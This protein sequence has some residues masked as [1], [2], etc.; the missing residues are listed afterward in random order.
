MFRFKYFRTTLLLLID[1]FARSSCALADDIRDVKPP[2]A[3]PANNF[4]FFLLLIFVIV[5]AVI[6]L[7][8]FFVTRRKKK[9]AAVVIR[10]AWC[11]A[12]E[13]F[14]MLEKEDLPGQ[15]KIKEF[16]SRLSAIVRYYVENRFSIN[17]PDM[18]TEE[19]LYSLE[20][21]R[22]F[23]PEQSSA[24]KNFLNCCDMVKFAKYGSTAEEIARSFSLARCFVDETKEEIILR[25][26]QDAE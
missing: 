2:V 10:P 22:E 20:S 23:S 18:T 5:A 7:V 12:Y 25:Q 1:V 8:Y 13:A 16:Y 21:A 14:D 4:W 19:F 6:F 9:E 26:T 15:G 17:A 3:F 24:V 11:I